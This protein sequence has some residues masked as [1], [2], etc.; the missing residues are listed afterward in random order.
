MLHLLFFFTEALK[1][2]IDKSEKNQK[3]VTLKDI[4][5]DLLA[6][7]KKSKYSENIPKPQMKCNSEVQ[8]IPLFRYKTLLE[9][10][11]ITKKVFS[12]LLV[13]SAIDFPIKDYDFGVPLGLWLLKS[14]FNLQGTKTKR[15]S[16]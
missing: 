12:V 3:S 6:T 8:E 2:Q 11:K 7:I 4:Y 1:H 9:K 15:S 16:V 5:D 14:Y 10:R 13:K